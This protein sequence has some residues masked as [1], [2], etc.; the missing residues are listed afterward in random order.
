VGF[1][2]HKSE[3]EQT[4]AEFSFLPELSF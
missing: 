3:S 2:Q 1:K 4:M